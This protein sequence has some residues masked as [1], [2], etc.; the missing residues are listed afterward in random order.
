MLPIYREVYLSN[1]VIL[2]AHLANVYEL[3]RF[4]GWLRL[5]LVPTLQTHMSCKGFWATEITLSA[6]LANIHELHKFFWAN[7]GV[8]VVD[9][10]RFCERGDLCC[11][12]LEVKLRQP[13]TARVGQYSLQ[14]QSSPLEGLATQLFFSLWCLFVKASVRD[15]FSFFSLSCF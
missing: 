15:K 13:I 1:E 6:Y 11:F 3:R 7:W 10:R 4:F 12:I 14:E 5:L 8:V 9:Y 2:S